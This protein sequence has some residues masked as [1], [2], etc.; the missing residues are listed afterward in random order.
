MFTFLV[1]LFES[2]VGAFASGQL[3]DNYQKH[4][5]HSVQNKNHH[6]QDEK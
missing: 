4:K 5:K 3:I 1:N 2:I 6:Q